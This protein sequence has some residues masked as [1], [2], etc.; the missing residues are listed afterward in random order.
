M[1]TTAFA[2]LK[3]TPILFAYDFLLPFLDFLSNV[4]DRKWRVG[5]FGFRKKCRA[6]CKRADNNP[7]AEIDLF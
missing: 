4:S 6:V 3:I 2:R 7:S 1:S 5:I